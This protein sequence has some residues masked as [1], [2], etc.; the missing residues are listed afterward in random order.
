MT[1]ISE[2]KSRQ[3][4]ANVLGAVFVLF[5]LIFWGV[6]LKQA[7]D[8]HD[9]RAES[10]VVAHKDVELERKGDDLR[11]LFSELYTNTRTIS[12]LPMI[13]S[14][15]GE[16]RRSATED[17]V[18]A[19]RF[20]LDAHHTMQQIY[21]NLQTHLRVSEIYYVLDGF[22]RKRGD[23]P[24]LMYDDLIV[25]RGEKDRPAESTADV[26]E[27][28]EEFEYEHFP[29]QLTWFR[30][31][32]PDF[33]FADRLD[34]IPV[35]LS[36]MMR[37]CDNSQFLSE[38]NGNVRDVEG[39]IYAMPVY[40]LDGARLRGMITAI[41]RNNTLEARLI[42]VPYLPLTRSDRDRMGR[43]GWAMPAEASTFLLRNAEYGIDIFDR[44]HAGLAKGISQ[45]LESTDGRWFKSELNLR[46]GAPWQLHYHMSTAEIDELTAGV[47]AD[48]RQ[49]L[50]GRLGLLVLLLATLA[51]VG[52]LVRRGRRELMW[53]A[54]YDA[55]TELPNRRAFFE[56]LKSGLA[57]AERNQSRAGLFFIDIAGFNAVNDTLGQRA[58]DLLLSVVGQRLV[59]CVR[60]SDV[61]TRNPVA[62][63]VSETVARL[64][65][66][67]FTILCEDLKSTD[68]LVAVAERLMTAM[69]EPVM[70][71][72]NEVE[73][74]L[75]V[76]I[77]AYPEDAADGEALLMAAESAMQMCRESGTGFLLYNEEMRK[78]AA[79]QH[80]LSL[81][82]NLALERQ[83]FQLFY[84]PKADI[85]SGRVVSLE[86]LLRWHHPEHGLV[87]PVEFIPLL[88]RSGRIV[89]VGEWVLQQSCR[90][91]AVLSQAGHDELKVSANVS[92]RQLRRGNFHETVARVLAESGTAPQRL[93][94]EITESMVMEN[95]QEG[96]LAL[97][98]LEALGV[99]LAIDDFGSGF[100]SLTY[101]QY[102]PLNYLKLD[103]SFIDGMTNDRARHIVRTVIVLAKG[104]NLATIAEGIETEAQRDELRE[105]G[106]EMIQGYWLS[107]PKPLPEIMAWLASRAG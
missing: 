11:K 13:R 37:T 33:T 21:T 78:R 47:R 100:S 46:T 51:W 9:Q 90:D 69:S 87:S 36:P 14:V 82:L 57:R 107:K 80:Q 74:S 49:T 83:Q 79:R 76:G 61:V 40:S 52:W 4:L 30:Q 50:F 70:V 38:Q 88:E 31:H 71:N 104:L 72:G 95:L 92:V 54:H 97:E 2:N 75:Y 106:C 26:P 59:E 17:V 58:G 48:R 6:E 25:G 68:D 19:G 35:R 39:M 20:S 10:I 66:D 67:E 42:G 86:A 44:R 32:A 3:R 34:Q 12:L 105:L 84:Q 43:E 23:V 85:N 64:G 5:I 24:F 22:D 96:Q 1:S 28:V 15:S 53:M 18:A 41:V 29:V 91:I 63:R 16:N 94:L 27:E 101:L 65:G 77:A 81:D 45:A 8:F 55:L 98:R 89:E 93:I 60:G 102:L 103:K 73:V 62:H 7:L 56:R 99:P